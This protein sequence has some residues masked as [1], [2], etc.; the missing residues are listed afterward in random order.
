MT[1]SGSYL[2]NYGG[3]TVELGFNNADAANLI[4]YLVKDLDLVSTAT[5]ESRLDV[6][7]S[8]P[9]PIFTCA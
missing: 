6:V 2:I 9:K 3:H 1:A 8:G 5:P 4:H 7:A